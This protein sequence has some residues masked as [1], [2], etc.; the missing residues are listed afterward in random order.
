MFPLAVA[1]AIVEGVSERIEFD[2]DKG[3]VLSPTFG[4]CLKGAVLPLPFAF[5]S[6]TVLHRRAYKDVYHALTSK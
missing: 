1:L 6:S 4:A 3:G 2:R 5:R